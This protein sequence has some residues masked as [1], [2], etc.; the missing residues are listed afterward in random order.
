ML[1][2]VK[3]ARGALLKSLQCVDVVLSYRIIGTPDE[4]AA[5]IDTSVLALS[6]R[7]AHFFVSRFESVG[8]GKGVRYEY[9]NCYSSVY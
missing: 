8:P 4:A 5:E 3:D 1:V 2:S 6:V 7:F 9:F